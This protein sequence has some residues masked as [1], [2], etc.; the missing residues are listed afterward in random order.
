[1][2][3]ERWGGKSNCIY[4]ASPSAD[5][6]EAWSVVELDQE[7][8]CTG[9]AV[10]CSYRS[11]PI[12]V[13]TI[14]SNGLQSLWVLPS[15]V[16]GDG[17]W[18]QQHLALLTCCL[19]VFICCVIWVQSLRESWGLPCASNARQRL[20]NARQSLCRAFFIEAHGKGHTVPYCTVK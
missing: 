15:L 5:S 4:W 11:R 1:M 2:N 19:N 10:G 12:P 13:S 3:P 17:Q 7:V 18:P 14:H 8:P 6:D 16:Y 20:E 9:A